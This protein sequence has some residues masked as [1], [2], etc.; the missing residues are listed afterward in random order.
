MP[1]VIQRENSLAAG[2]TNDNLLSGSAFEY[3][4]F[5]SLVSIGCV[6]S[7]TGSFITIQMG[8]TVLLEESPPAIRTA[9]PIQPDD[10]YY[11]G[12]A[13]PGDRLVVRARNPT[14]GAI[15]LRTVV[16]LTEAG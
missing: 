15:T 8:P 9:M 6:A 2:V 12:F 10:F 11:S 3:A 5:P 14:G 1:A 7:A 4:R 16:Q 13:A